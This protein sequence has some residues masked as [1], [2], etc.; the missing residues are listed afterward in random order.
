MRIYLNRLGSSQAAEG[1]PQQIKMKDKSFI[2]LLIYKIIYPNPRVSSILLLSTILDEE[3]ARVAIGRSELLTGLQQ[4]S[5]D[6]QCPS[7][8]QT[9]TNEPNECDLRY[10][11]PAPRD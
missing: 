10:G 7:V 4:A 8:S 11:S 5:F 6:V 1:R 9:R 2:F 3:S